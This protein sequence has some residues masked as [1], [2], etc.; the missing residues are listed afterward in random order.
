MMK[1]IIVAI[2]VVTAYF[3]GNLTGYAVGYNDRL[4]V[5]V[6]KYRVNKKLVGRR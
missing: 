1:M 6:A 4:T 5:E 2:F 3:L